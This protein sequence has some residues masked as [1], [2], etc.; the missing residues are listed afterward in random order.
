[1][2]EL[3]PCPFCGSAVR[4]NYNI[5]GEPAGILCINCHALTTFF[6]AKLKRGDTFGKVMDDMA[7]AWNRRVDDERDCQGHEDA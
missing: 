1:M 3:K 4:Y 7:T 6:R 5:E 2:T